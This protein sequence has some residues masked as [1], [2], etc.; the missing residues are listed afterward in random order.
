MTNSN[1]SPA[2]LNKLLEIIAIFVGSWTGVIFHTIW[3]IFW[4]ILRL[5]INLLTMIVSLEAIFICIFLLMASNREEAQ[6][7]IDLGKEKEQD[8]EQMTLDIK[9]DQK[10]DRQLTEIKR[11]QQ[12][13]HAEIKEVLTCLKC[14]PKKKG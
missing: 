10:A 3:F 2:Y 5:D 4:F 12:E 9:L 8:R 7:K 11:V 14:T 13:L 1:S 6:R